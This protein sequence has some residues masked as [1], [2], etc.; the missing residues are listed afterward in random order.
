MSVLT[1]ARGQRAD[2][3]FLVSRTFPRAVG[4]IVREVLV[5]LCGEHDVEWRYLGKR[6]AVNEEENQLKL[7]TVSR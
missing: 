2:I 7:E 6:A 3:T 5:L 4:H 1:E